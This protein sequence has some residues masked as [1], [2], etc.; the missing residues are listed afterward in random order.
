VSWLATRLAATSL[1]AGIGV[2]AGVGVVSS[3]TWCSRLTVVVGVGRARRGWWG[4]LRLGCWSW[5]WHTA[6]S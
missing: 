6:R 4:P 3:S 1:R 5:W 2:V